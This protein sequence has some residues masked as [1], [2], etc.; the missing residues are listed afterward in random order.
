MSGHFGNRQKLFLVRNKH[1]IVGGL[2]LLVWIWPEKGTFLG[3][4]TLELLGMVTDLLTSQEFLWGKTRKIFQTELHAS[5]QLISVYSIHFL[6]S[7]LTDYLFHPAFHARPS[8]FYFNCPDSRF[9]GIFQ[10]GWVI[11]EK[12]WSIISRCDMK[13][14]TLLLA[15]TWGR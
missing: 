2:G 4:D 14:F 10:S 1:Y 3:H 13:S 11:R 6:I 7:H 12:G 15:L 8:E 5:T 9:R